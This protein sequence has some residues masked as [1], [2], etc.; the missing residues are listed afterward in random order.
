MRF[1]TNAD[2]T[3][4]KT[5]N[6]RPDDPTDREGIEYRPMEEG[7]EVLIDFDEDDFEEGEDFFSVDGEEED[8]EEEEEEDEHDGSRSVCFLCVG[9]F[10]PAMAV[11]G[12]GHFFFQV[13]GGLFTAVAVTVIGEYGIKPRLFVRRGGVLLSTIMFV[14]TSYVHMTCNLR[15]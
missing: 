3:K 13:L 11:A 6:W 14:T 9:A 4:S 10:L 1:I 15:T 7:D 5:T 2:E 12:Q 8:E